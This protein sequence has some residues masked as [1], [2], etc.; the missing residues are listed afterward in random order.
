[1][2]GEGYNVFEKQ[3]K[4]AKIAEYIYMATR[5]DVISLADDEEYRSKDIDVK[6]GVK[7]VEIKCEPRAI[8]T[9]NFYIELRNASN[10]KH[11]G[12]GYFYYSEAD[13][14]CFIDMR[15]CVIYW[16]NLSYF[17]QWVRPL[18]LKR[19]E[20]NE[21]DWGLLL[22]IEYLKDWGIPKEMRRIKKFDKK[23]LDDAL[24]KYGIDDINAVS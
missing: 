22:P 15:E 4:W 7:F 6:D 17:R 24:K 12:Q 13:Y 8:K 1:M 16:I 3:V 14:I 2:L 19:F 21:A 5:R 23:I 9:R 20:K 10:K 11:N 18:C